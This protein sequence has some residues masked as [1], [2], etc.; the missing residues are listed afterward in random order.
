MSSHARDAR[1]LA[2][3]SAVA[4]GLLVV[5]AGATGAVAAGSGSAGPSGPPPMTTSSA[6]ATPSGSTSASGGTTTTVWKF[7]SVNTLSNMYTVNGQPITNPST[8]PAVGDYFISTDNDY[9]GT[10]AGHS[11]DV[12][13]TDH[14]FCLFTKLPGTATCSAQIGTS[15]GMLLADNSVQNFASQSPTITLKITGGTGAYQGATGTVAVTSIANTSNSNA[16]V[17]WSK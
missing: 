9:A 15:Q 16:V 3:A 12:S 4:A 2:A 13:A 7:Y 10:Q 11:S 5:T 14:I 6:G 8:S 17:T 1:F